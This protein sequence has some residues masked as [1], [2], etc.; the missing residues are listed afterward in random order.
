[1][2]CL[3]RLA[4]ASLRGDK[5]SA[6]KERRLLAFRLLHGH[7]EQLT[8]TRAGIHWTVE[9]DS[10]VVPR[11][12][13]VR[14]KAF[15][16]LRAALVKWLTAYGCIS[17]RRRT[18]IDIGANI[19]TPS[20]QLARE[21][22]LDVL[23]IEP[24]PSN[25]ELL[26]R[27]VAQNG[28]DSKI[29]CLQAAV[30]THPGTVKMAVPKER[31]ACEVVEEGRQPGFG[32][33]TPE[34]PVIQVPSL[35]L[36]TILETHAIAAANIAVVWCDVQ[37]LEREVIESA[38]GVWRAGVPLY[39]ELW[40]KGMEAHGGVRAFLETVQANFKS[41]VMVSEMIKI[42]AH[43]QPRPLNEL[44]KVVEAIGSSHD[45]ALLI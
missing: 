38:P 8:F 11:K 19:G 39:L 40:P 34:I 2:R 36:E 18:L 28:L 4:L 22:D 16:P 26:K 21:T 10:G 33:L 29:R 1:M 35:R 7:A 25:F 12:L 9:V 17:A 45:D 5:A 15:E 31:A 43:A 27:N 23:A 14:E 42:G 20:V 32:P 41:F 24:V 6:V 30:S 44:Q 3:R 13:F 37:G